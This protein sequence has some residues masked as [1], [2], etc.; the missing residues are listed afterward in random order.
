MYGITF[1]PLSAKEQKRIARAE[2]K[3][4]RKFLKECKKNWAK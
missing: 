3:A 2:K 4:R 1:K